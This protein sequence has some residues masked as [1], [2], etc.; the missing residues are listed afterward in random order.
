M[1]ASFPRVPP[2]GADRQN[3]ATTGCISSRKCRGPLARPSSCSTARLTASL[4]V[5]RVI[6][7]RVRWFGQ[8]GSAAAI[9]TFLLRRGLVTRG[10]SATRIP[11]IDFSNRFSRRA[12]VLP[13]ACR[14]RNAGVGKRLQ[15]VDLSHGSGHGGL[16]LG[17]RR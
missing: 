9:P 3:T 5:S 10:W 11:D 15:N 16:Q 12:R 4:I 13:S 14:A 1:A 8:R 2:A 7:L 6:L 17:R